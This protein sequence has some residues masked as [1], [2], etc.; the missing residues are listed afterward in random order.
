VIIVVVVAVAVTTRRAL[1]KMKELYFEVHHI[2]SSTWCT[3]I[4]V[5]EFSLFS[6]SCHEKDFMLLAMIGTVM[7]VMM[8]GIR[9]TLKT[10][11]D[12]FKGLFAQLIH[13]NSL[14]LNMLTTLLNKPY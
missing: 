4:Q 1:I 12:D 3:F 5:C 9:T 13:Q 11:L 7:T 14:I 10:F 8:I 2:S 6:M